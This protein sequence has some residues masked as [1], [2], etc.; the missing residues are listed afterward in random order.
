[1]L[2]LQLKNEIDASDVRVGDE[3]E[4]ARLLSPLILEDHAV[5][6][7]AEVGEVGLKHAELEIV[8]EA[9]NKHFS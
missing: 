9:A 1:M 3:T 8:G 5:L 2:L 7:L 6:N 4:P